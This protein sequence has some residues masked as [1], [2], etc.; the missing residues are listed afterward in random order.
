MHN[1][2]LWEDQT[3]AQLGAVEFIKIV[4]FFNKAAGK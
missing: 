3:Q 4:N 2:T 1:S